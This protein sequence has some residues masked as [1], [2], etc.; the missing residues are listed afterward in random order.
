METRTPTL[1]QILLPLAFGLLCV[2]L[3]IAVWRSFGG[4]VPLEPREYQVTTTFPQAS[5]LFPEADVRAAGVDIGRVARVRRVD[6]RAEVTM[7]IDA[8]FA[9]L[10]A[11]ARAILRTKTLLGETFVEVAPGPSSAPLIEDG[12]R[13]PSDRVRAAQRLDD[14]LEAFAP[15]TRRDLRRLIDGMARALDG[16]AGSL[17]GA[18]ANAAPAV[19]GVG[20][21]LHR[22]RGQEDDLRRLVA[23]SADVLAAVG[24]RQGDLQ[25]AITAAD[26]LLA[27]SARRGRDLGAV[28]D[29]LPPFLRQLR[30]T[31]DRLGVASPDLRAAAASLRRV[32]PALP[33]ALQAIIRDG[34]AYELLLTRLGPVLRAGTRTLPSLTRTLADARTALPPVDGALRQLLPVL[35]LLRANR[36]SVH[37]VL[38]NV[39]QIQNGTMVGPGGRTIHYGNGLP[40]IWNEIVGGWIKRLPTNRLNPYPK[41]ES[42]RDIATGG[43]KAYDCRNLGNPLYLPALGSG[44]P[45]CVEQGPWTFNG[46]RAYFPRLLEAPPTIRP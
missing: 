39:A 4:S 28:V 15:S 46:K 41:P 38:A 26:Q 30:R 24:A 12:G 20:A 32:A 22:A 13:L 27:V 37:G 8:R 29:E 19:E 3:A 16:R 33:P 43:L 34:P 14:V 31:T 25:A 44:A 42:L 6:G 18:S 1:R 2:I 21:V 45:P 9:P 5:N 10:R 40:T 7:A 17:N 11:Q 23:G 35:Q 36:S